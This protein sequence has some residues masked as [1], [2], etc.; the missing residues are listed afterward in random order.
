[1]CRC[2]DRVAHPYTSLCFQYFGLG[3]CYSL[4]LF[5]AIQSMK[6]HL[7]IAFGAS[8]SFYTSDAQPFQDSV[9]GNRAAPA[10]WLIT[11]VFLIR[12][13]YKQKVVTYITSPISK[14][15][16]FIATL[17]HVDDTDLYAFNNGF[18]CT[19]ELITKAQRLLNA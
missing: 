12:H 7:H 10:L 3:I 16:Q 13:L 5:Q 9:Q 14:R 1:M 19:L 11:S 15:S 4:V 17:M 6:M 18:M 8:T 2:Y